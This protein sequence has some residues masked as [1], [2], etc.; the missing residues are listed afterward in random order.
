MA[1]RWK[2]AA[3]H[4][5]SKT[6]SS[7][8]AKGKK[9]LSHIITRKAKSGG[10][11]HEHHHVDAEAHP[12]ETHVSSDQ[13]AMAAHMVASL[14]DDAPASGDPSDPTGDASAAPAAAGAAP[15]AAA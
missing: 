5:E 14:G 12:A 6:S 13:D 9:T 11:T 10:F 3:E 8:K 15:A 4:A 1:S 7:T 2:D